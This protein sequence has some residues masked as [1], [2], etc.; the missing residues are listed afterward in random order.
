MPPEITHHFD[1][2]PRLTLLSQI[3][4]PHKIFCYLHHPTHRISLPTLSVPKIFALP[5][6]LTAHLR[7]AANLHLTDDKELTLRKKFGI[8]SHKAASSD[9]DFETLSLLERL[10]YMTAITI[11]QLDVTNQ[12]LPHGDNTEDSWQCLKR[13]R[14]NTLCT[15][16]QYLESVKVN[17]NQT[18]LEGFNNELSIG[19][20][21]P[22]RRTIGTIVEGTHP[23]FTGNLERLYTKPT[24]LD[25]YNYALSHIRLTAKQY[26]TLSQDASHGDREVFESNVVVTIDSCLNFLKAALERL[27]SI[28]FGETGNEFITFL[29]FLNPLSVHLI[30]THD[31]HSINEVNRNIGITMGWF[32]HHDITTTRH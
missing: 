4:T 25:K 7:F 17:P 10:D 30:N 31:V 28:E 29:V 12:A 22:S 27:M 6:D 23:G 13:T 16:I 14:L 11:S 24:L 26:D 9:L 5:G 20:W 2:T 15:H 32:E 8:A 3:M 19:P 21:R 18:C 1:D